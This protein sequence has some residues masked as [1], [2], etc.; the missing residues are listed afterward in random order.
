MLLRHG[1]AVGNAEGRL[2]G[3]MD[4]P[5]TEKGRT[6]AAPLDGCHRSVRDG[7]PIDHE[8]SRS[9]QEHGRGARPRSS[10]RDRRS[11]DRGRLRELRR[12]AAV[13]RSFRGLAHMAR[14]PG[15]QAARRR[16]PGGARCACPRRVRG[17]VLDRRGRGEGR[18]RRD[19][20]QPRLADKGGRVLGA[21]GGRRH[22]VAHVACD[23]VADGHRM[24]CRRA[25]AAP[26][27]H[28][29]AE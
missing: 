12:R 27:Q 29:F 13:G 2:L 9:S 1:E 18:H 17:A 22:G 28:R 26:L 14:R 5:L 21:R 16:D 19:R 11:L 23:R 24:G 20:R 25:C 4:S 10:D 15:V 6:Q 7:L 8:P 3:R